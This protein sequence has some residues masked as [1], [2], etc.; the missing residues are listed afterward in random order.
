MRK[1][2]VIFLF[3]SSLLSMALWQLNRLASDTSLSQWENGA[4]GF[5]SAMTQHDKNAKP[6][7]LFFHT[8]WCQSCKAL[9]SNV[10]GQQRVIEYISKFNA[11]QINPEINQANREIAIQYSVTAFPT[12]IL[13]R[14]GGNSA[15]RLPVGGKSTV[16]KFIAACESALRK[17][18]T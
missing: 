6:V 15:I 14:N 16:D 4:A 8:D 17:I 12:L 5:R 1:L 3:I 2:L 7:L 9:E 18:N 10:L 13:I 11:V